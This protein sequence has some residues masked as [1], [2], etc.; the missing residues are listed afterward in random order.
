MPASRPLKSLAFPSVCCGAAR[1]QGGHPKINPPLVTDRGGHQL[2]FMSSRTLA[3]IW[4]AP[5]WGAGLST[6]PDPNPFSYDLLHPGG[7]LNPQFVD[8]H[9]LATPT[10][11]LAAPPAL[12]PHQDCIPFHQQMSR[13]SVYQDGP[14]LPGDQK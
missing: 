14:C 11:P 1:V 8:P 12:T 3:A 5:G 4:P 2:I 10:G 7:D 9:G 6:S 13:D